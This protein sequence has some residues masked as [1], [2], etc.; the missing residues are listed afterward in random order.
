MGVFN[1]VRYTVVAGIE[2]LLDQVENQEAVVAASI[3]DV[4]RALAR[5]HVHRKRCERRIGQLESEL[6]ALA[7]EIR[8]WRDRTLRLRD[9]RE[10]ALECVRRSRTSERN[11]QQRQ[12][13]L[14]G[15]PIPVAYVA[16]VDANGVMSG[17]I[18]IAGG[19]ATGTFTA[20]RAG[21]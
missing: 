14:Q 8:T 20:R 12:A 19:L 21:E 11:R 16:T 3:R 17:T 18:D 6:S 2:S 4:E 10:Q 1:R 5:I 9:D 15:Q 7:E 13:E